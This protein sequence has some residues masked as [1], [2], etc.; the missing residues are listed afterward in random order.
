MSQS[1]FKSS[2]QYLE[3]TFA[4]KPLQC[5]GTDFFSHV[6]QHSQSNVSVFSISEFKL[7]RHFP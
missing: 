5:S 3:A 1:F 7:A 2:L 4:T 6:K